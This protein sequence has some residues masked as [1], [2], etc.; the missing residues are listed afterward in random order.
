MLFIISPFLMLFINNNMNKRISTIR[1]YIIIF[2][3]FK[4]FCT[5]KGPSTNGPLSPK[6]PALPLQKITCIHT[7][8][9]RRDCINNKPSADQLLMQWPFVRQLKNKQISLLKSSIFSLILKIIHCYKVQVTQLDNSYPE[10][11]YL[12]LIFQ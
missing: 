4:F 11:L 7:K 3:I 8:K 10:V 5:K 1:I 9:I 2:I 6:T 12:Y